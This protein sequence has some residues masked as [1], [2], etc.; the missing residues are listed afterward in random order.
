MN[1]A[2]AGTG[3]NRRVAGNRTDA[4]QWRSQLFW[5]IV[6]LWLAVIASSLGVVYV[7]YDTRAKL[8][9]LE[10]LR[11]Q[12]SELQV[13]WGQYLLE[14]STWAAYGRVE[15]LARER[16]AMKIPDSVSIV[17]VENGIKVSANE[18]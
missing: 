18:D 6:A 10:S 13:V 12:Q 17:M 15:K 4:S 11:R 2:A 7:A 9:E 5:W 8:N 14:E 1:R 16:L 3:L